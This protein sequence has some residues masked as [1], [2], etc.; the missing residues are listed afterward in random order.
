MTIVRRVSKQAVEVVEPCYDEDVDTEGMSPGLAYQ[1]VS[2]GRWSRET[3]MDWV[4]NHDIEVHN[5]AVLTVAR[6]GNL[7]TDQE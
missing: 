5:E 1:Y 6:L 2:T 3:F 7:A 4:F